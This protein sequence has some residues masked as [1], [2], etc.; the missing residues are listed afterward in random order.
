MKNWF[1]LI[2]IGILVCTL[3]AISEHLLDVPGFLYFCGGAAFALYVEW[4]I[5]K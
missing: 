1:R 3:G 4:E 2:V 5:E